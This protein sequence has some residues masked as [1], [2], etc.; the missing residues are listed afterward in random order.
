MIHKGLHQK[1]K[2]EPQ[3]LSLETRVKS[4]ATEG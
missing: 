1:L 4:Y 2:I 3:E